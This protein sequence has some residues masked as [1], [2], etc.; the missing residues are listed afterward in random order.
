MFFFFIILQ[1]S[2][3][4]IGTTGAGGEYVP[5]TG[6]GWTNGFILEILNTWGKFLNWNQISS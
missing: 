2:A 3:V 5:Q 4:E 1:Y 6:F